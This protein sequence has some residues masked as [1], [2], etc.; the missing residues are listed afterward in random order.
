MGQ[1]FVD[2]IED[3][4]APGRVYSQEVVRLALEDLGGSRS[5]AAHENS[6]EPPLV[7]GFCT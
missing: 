6:S 3:I 4:L 5:M 1:A 2:R 7:V